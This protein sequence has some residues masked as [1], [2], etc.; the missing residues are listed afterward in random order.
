MIIPLLDFIFT[1][2]LQGRHRIIPF[3]S[4]D[5]VWR[6]H[7]AG[8]RSLIPGTSASQLSVLTHPHLPL[9]SDWPCHYEVKYPH[10]SFFSESR[11]HSCPP[12]Q[13]VSSPPFGHWNTVS[14]LPLCVTPSS[15]RRHAFL[16]HS[17]PWVGKKHAPPKWKIFNT[18]LIPVI[19]KYP[20]RSQPTATE[21]FATGSSEN[22]KAKS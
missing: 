19:P 10:L 2:V 17:N 8:T 12:S 16:C 15:L 20:L 22:V 1:I 4:H 21:S 13:C 18:F 9:P 11:R 7:A 5:R 14:S 6:Q 3:Q